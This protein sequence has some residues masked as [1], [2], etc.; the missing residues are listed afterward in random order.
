MKTK[1][2]KIGEWCSGG[3]ITVE[4]RGKVIS[5]INKQWDFS[6]GTRRSSNQTNAEEIERGTI[7]VNEDGAERKIKN[8][9]S[10]LS[11][12]YWADQILKWIKSKVKLE[13]E[14]NY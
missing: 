1:T 3:I 7:L 12:S 5:V 10:D 6:Q 9:I 11:T 2:F 14:Y 4:I 8:Y 13:V